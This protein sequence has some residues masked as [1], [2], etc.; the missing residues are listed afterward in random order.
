MG[1]GGALNLIKKKTKNFLLINGDTIFCIDIDDFL[2][3]SNN[4]NWIHVTNIK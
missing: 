4:K 2:K 1:T 3:S